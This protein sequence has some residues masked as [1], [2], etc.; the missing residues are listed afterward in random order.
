MMAHDD[1]RV[2]NRGLIMKIKNEKNFNSNRASKHVESKSV[3][4][5]VAKFEA[6]DEDSSM[7]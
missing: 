3:S 7:N 5:I 6:E 1:G 4:L 2:I